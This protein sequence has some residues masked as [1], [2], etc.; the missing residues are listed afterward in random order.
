MELHLPRIQFENML[1]AIERSKLKRFKI[2]TIRTQQQLQILT[3]SIPSMKLP[4]LVIRY[5]GGEVQNVK[6]ELL[7]A[8]K[9]NF[10]LLSVKG[11]TY[12]AIDRFNQSDKHRLAFYANRNENLNQWVDNPET[13]EQRKVWPEAL[14]LAQRAGPDALFRSLRSVLESDYVIPKGGRKRQRPQHLAPS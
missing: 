2:G 1:R 6:E 14:G 9:N 7:Q 5:D 3:Q 11:E 12:E 4:D 13:V 8:V 10:T